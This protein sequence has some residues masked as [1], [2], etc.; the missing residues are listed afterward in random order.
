MTH[1][2]TMFDLIDCL[3]VTAKNEY[4]AEKIVTLQSGEQV[5]IIVTV[6]DTE[7]QQI[8]DKPKVARKLLRNMERLL[9]DI[10]KSIPKGVD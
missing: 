2:E 5:K 9:K 10:E 7:E 4:K 6:A 3:K 8:S 1:Y